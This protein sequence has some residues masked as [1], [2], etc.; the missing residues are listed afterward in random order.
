M[1]KHA[2]SSRRAAPGRGPVCAQS[3]VRAR[4]RVPARA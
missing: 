4:I 2:R 3:G 1:R